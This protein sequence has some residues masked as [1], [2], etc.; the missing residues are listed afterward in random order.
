VRIALGSDEDT[1]LPRALARHLEDQGHFVDV[2]GL[3]LVWPAIGR[4]V[5]EAVASGRADL[6]IVCCWT[7]TG[8]SIAANKVKGVR[9]ALCGDA[10]TADG[11]RKWNDANVLALSIRSTSEALGAEIV[12]A[13]LA[14]RPDP[15]ET[16]VLGQLE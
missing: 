2:V 4:A 15:E 13:F 3:S 14:G 10:P 9:A 6:G 1:A 16:A 5:G 7:G 11:A 12:D 8:V